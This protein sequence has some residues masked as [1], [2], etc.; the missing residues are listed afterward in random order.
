MAIGGPGGVKKFN[1]APA[2]YLL[3]PSAVPQF[4]APSRAGEAVADPVTGASF[5]AVDDPKLFVQFDNGQVVYVR[6]AAS[7]DALRADV[8][9]YIAA[10]PRADW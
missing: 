7:A 2:H 4:V 9:S 5:A 3:D 8:A 6:D 1:A 10:L